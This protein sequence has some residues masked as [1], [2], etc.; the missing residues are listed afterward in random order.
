MT[1]RVGGGGG[2][3]ATLTVRSSVGRSPPSWMPRFIEMKRSTFGLSF[4]DGLCRLVFSMMIAN[5]S[6]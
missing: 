5:D 3:G 2:R 6:T 4:T 1:E